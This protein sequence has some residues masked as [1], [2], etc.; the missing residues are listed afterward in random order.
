MT[1]NEQWKWAQRARLNAKIAVL[2]AVEAA[3]EAEREYHYARFVHVAASIE[4]PTCGA[5]SGSY[6]AIWRN[7]STGEFFAGNGSR[8]LHLVALFL[9]PARTTS[10]AALAVAGT[11]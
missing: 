10:E 9:H 4:C 2:D 8:D 6:C 1:P 7:E 5:A 3:E 11:S